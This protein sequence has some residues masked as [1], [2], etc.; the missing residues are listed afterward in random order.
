MFFFALFVGAVLLEARCP[1]IIFFLADDLGYGDLGCYNAQT[2]INA[3]VLDGLANSGLRFTDHYASAPLCAPSRRA[4]LTGRWQS[5]LGEWAELYGGTPYKDGIPAYKEPTVAMF[6]NNAGYATACFG[7]WNIGG[8]QGVSCPGAHGFD[9]YLCVDHNTDYFFHQKWDG[10]KDLFNDGLGLYTNGG[11]PKEL[12]GKYL[13]DVF[14]D[15]AI[16]FI[17]DNKDRPF[18]IY[19]SWC[20][21]HTPMQGPDDINDTKENPIGKKVKG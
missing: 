6:L 16:E 15:A 9:E 8:M 5:R 7:K 12:P 3:P 20:V 21:P 10:Q 19:L 17:E 14:G 2:D 11:N 1:N 4:F 18:F 13:P